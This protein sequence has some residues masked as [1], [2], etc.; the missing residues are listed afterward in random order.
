MLKHMHS[1]FLGGH[2]QKIDFRSFSFKLLTKDNSMQCKKPQQK[3][4]IQARVIA[5]QS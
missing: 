2:S 1:G 4:L 5:R 3:N